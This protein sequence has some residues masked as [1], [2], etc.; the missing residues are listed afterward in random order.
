MARQIGC[1]TIDAEAI[2]AAELMAKDLP[3][4]QEAARTAG[5]AIPLGASAQKIVARFAE[6]GGRCSDYAGVIDLL[7]QS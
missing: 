4:S 6:N 5:A 7:R 3:P 1:S 2:V